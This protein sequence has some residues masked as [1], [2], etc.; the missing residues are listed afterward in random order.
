M[1][2]CVEKS[3]KKCE[4]FWAFCNRECVFFGCGCFGWARVLVSFFVL[5][6]DE[7]VDDGV[8]SS[9]S[10]CIALSF[11][12]FF[13]CFL[14]VPSQHLLLFS[15]HSFTVSFFSPSPP[16][17]CCCIRVHIH[18]LPLLL[19]G[20]SRSLFTQKRFVECFFRFLCRLVSQF[21]FSSSQWSFL[22]SSISLERSI[23]AESSLS[24]STFI[25]IRRQQNKKSNNKKQ[26]TKQLS[27]P[28]A[29][30]KEREPTNQQN[31]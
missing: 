7:L 5:T 31:Q 8:S 3:T 4:M 13:S 20:H 6:C 14:F 17:T 18:C 9:S 22:Y 29:S 25:P 2:V 21:L 26:T 27:S 23:T 19:V 15:F 16:Q 1:S 10:F 12:L 11:A 28:D 30:L 24:F